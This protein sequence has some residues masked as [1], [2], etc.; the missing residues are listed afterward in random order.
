MAYC[1]LISFVQYSDTTHPGVGMSPMVSTL[2][3]EFLRSV[4]GLLRCALVCF[5]LLSSLWRFHTRGERPRLGPNFPSCVVQN[6]LLLG[7]PISAI[8]KMRMPHYSPSILRIWRIPSLCPRLPALP[9]AASKRCVS[10]H[11]SPQP[12][13][14]TASDLMCLLMPSILFPRRSNH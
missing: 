6:A 10:L 3:M 5:H 14:P 12:G 9:T 11:G 8:K 1:S 4:R 13:D 2:L 7:A